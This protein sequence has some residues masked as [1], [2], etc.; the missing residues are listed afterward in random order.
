[1]RARTLWVALGNP[2]ETEYVPI[3]ASTL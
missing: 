3:D 1:V 2:C